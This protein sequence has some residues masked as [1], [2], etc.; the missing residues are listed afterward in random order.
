M[1]Q[2]RGHPTSASTLSPEKQIAFALLIFERMLPSLIT[3]SKHTGLDGS[4]YLRARDLAWERLQGK[5]GS[6]D[7]MD[8]LNRLCLKSAPDTEDFTHEQ[9]SFALNAAVTMSE[10][11]EFMLNRNP[12][13]VSHV[14]TFATDSV[15]LY[16]SG[17][18]P[19]LITTK[20][21]INRI[22]AHTLMQQELDRQ[23]EDI[24]FLS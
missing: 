16:L 23:K 3:F 6:A 20:E 24:R 17:L 18:E 14:S 21:K 15:H 19:S 7:D 9:T 1:T 8:R 10:I 11:L 22:A 12:D 4:C 13:L 5:A 2:D